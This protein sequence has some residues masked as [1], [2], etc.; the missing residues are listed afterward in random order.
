MDEQLSAVVEK[1]FIDLYDEGLIYRGNRL[2]NWDP[3]LHTAISDLEVFSEEEP[4]TLWHYRYPLTNGTTTRSGDT[5]VTIATTRPETMLGDAAVAIHP[6]DERYIG[7]AGKFV[8]LPLC[9]RHIP[10]I[11]DEYVDPEFGSGCV[12]ITPAHDFNDYEIG[13]R[14]KFCLLYTSDAADE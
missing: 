13:K 14:H 11:V 10:I 9:N 2:V 4:G 6:T 12:K 7:L 1:V 8:E 5:F 3:Q